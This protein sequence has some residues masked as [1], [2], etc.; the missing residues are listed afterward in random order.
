MGRSAREESAAT[1]RGAEG[2]MVCRWVGLLVLRLDWAGS[3]LA[4]AIEGLAG[5]CSA[6]QLLLARGGCGVGRL[7]SIS[8]VHGRGHDGS[9]SVGERRMYRELG[10]VVSRDECLGLRPKLLLCAAAGTLEQRTRTQTGFWI[11]KHP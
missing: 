11:R 2:V 6:L 1:G 8:A 4:C 5:R 3:L 10:V 9:V 7:D